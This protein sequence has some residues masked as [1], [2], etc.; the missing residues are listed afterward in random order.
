MSFRMETRQNV[1]VALSGLLESAGGIAHGF[2]TRR[3][4]VSRGVWSELN[5]GALRGDEPERVAENWR[6]FCAAAGV[7]PGRVVRVKQVHGDRIC[8]VT[9]QGLAETQEADGLVTDAAGVALAV[10]TADC[11]PVLLCD[12]E[13]GCV[14]AVHSGWRGTALAICAKAVEQ[15]IRGYGCRPD[16]M[17]AAVGPGICP[18]CFETDADVPEAM[19]AALG[20]R[21]NDCIRPLGAGRYRV[22]LKGIVT[23]TLT[24]AGL[25]RA[26][27]DVSRH[28]TACMGETYWSHR[29]LGDRR[30]SMAAVIALKG[31]EI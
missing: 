18:S 15:M 29:R 28:C 12:P 10:L 6:R 20:A 27:I 4:G 23:R 13:R 25:D 24:D 11:I 3:G 16:R 8:A 31:R 22:D 17:L 30:G 5:L 14:A 21:V 9:E 7:D 1:P 2:S 26:H 19:T